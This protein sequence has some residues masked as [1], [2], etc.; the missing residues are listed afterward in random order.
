MTT[1]D[2]IFIKLYDK[3]ISILKQY[4]EIEIPPV[5]NHELFK[6]YLISQKIKTVKQLM[7]SELYNDETVNK[8]NTS[9][10]IKIENLIEGMITLIN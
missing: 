9:D 8:L 3:C 5:L 2:E 1:K 6:I 7:N 10:K 4:E